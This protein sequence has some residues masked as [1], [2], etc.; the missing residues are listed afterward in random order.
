MSRTRA[1]RACLTTYLTT[2]S[3]IFLFELRSFAIALKSLDLDFR[4]RKDEFLGSTFT[5][6]RDKRWYSP[7]S[8]AAAVTQDR[9]IHRGDDS[10]RR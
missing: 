10:R 9:K 6:S 3:D 5:E 4:R 2:T 8:T 1:S 7:T